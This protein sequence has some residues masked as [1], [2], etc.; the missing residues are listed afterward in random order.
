MVLNLNVKENDVGFVIF[1][2]IFIKFGKVFI[3]VIVIVEIFDDGLFLGEI[4]GL[5][6]FDMVVC[7]IFVVVRLLE[8]YCM[9]DDCLWMIGLCRVLEICC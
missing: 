5:I 7:S 1:L 9:F 4:I 8:V 3:K 6:V 2:I